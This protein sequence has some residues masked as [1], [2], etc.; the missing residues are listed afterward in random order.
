M[1]RYRFGILLAWQLL[2]PVQALALPA[3]SDHFYAAADFGLGV[4]KVDP[5]TGASL[6]VLFSSPGARDIELGP[7]GLLYVCNTSERLIQVVDPTSGALVHSIGF[8]IHPV[9]SLPATPLNIAFGPDRRL[10]VSVQD[11]PGFGNIYVAE[12]TASMV[13]E[14]FNSTN[15]DALPVGLQFGPDGDLYVTSV[16]GTGNFYH[17]LDRL[18]GSSGVV[19]AMVAS[20]ED[21]LA[22]A[23]SLTFS[24]DGTIYVGNGGFGSGGWITRHTRDGQYLGTLPT[25]PTNPQG[26]NFLPDG[27]L[28]WGNGGSSFK[29][30]D[31]VTQTTSDFGSGFINSVRMIAI[32]EP[33]AGLLALFVAIIGAVRIRSAA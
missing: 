4:L 30:Y 2:A 25:P 15:F 29:R 17:R 3:S 6:G 10:Y 9:F 21:N 1:N 12:P 7:G 33:T 32:P 16:N 11:V 20:Q 26:L 18:D 13:T 22:N 31:F 8:P 5:A 23:G 19:E 28:I 14:I 24:R 27:D